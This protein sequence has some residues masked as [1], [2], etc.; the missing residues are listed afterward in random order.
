MR[1]E[2][3]IDRQGREVRGLLGV[4][5]LGIALVLAFVVPP[6]PIRR[7]AVV[8]FTLGGILGIFEALRGWCVARAMGIR[9]PL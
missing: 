7:A 6:T 5:C 8:L 3:N 4:L 1:L 2:C 9:T